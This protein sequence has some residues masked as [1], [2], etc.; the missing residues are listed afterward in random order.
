MLSGWIGGIETT[1]A[2]LYSPAAQS[3]A[4]GSPRCGGVVHY[5]ETAPQLTGCTSGGHHHRICAMPRNSDA[6]QPTSWSFHPYPLVTSAPGYPYLCVSHPMYYGVPP[7]PPPVDDRVAAPPPPPY[8]RSTSARYPSLEASPRRQM[9]RIE[10][11]PN[12]R[13]K[14][15][16]HGRSNDTMQG[17]SRTMCN[18]VPRSAMIPNK[19]SPSYIGDGHPLAEEALEERVDTRSK[20]D[21]S[22]DPVLCNFKQNK[23]ENFTLKVCFLRFCLFLML[24]LFG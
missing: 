4:E 10:S 19:S 16:L 22:M 14:R 5:Y 13:A 8:R 1:H 9:T 17:I 11:M 7:P 18:F 21:T 24:M 6:T 23:G 12:S 15:E 3:V 2:M 20:L